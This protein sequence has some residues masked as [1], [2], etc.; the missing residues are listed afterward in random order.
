[1]SPWRFV[2]A[3]GLVSLLTDMVYEGA[4]SIIGPYLATL[5]ATAVV[6]GAVAGIGDFLGYGLRV[7]SGY[8]VQRSRR[9]WAWTIAGYALTVLSVPLIG[10]T[11]AIA[12]ALVLY[13][14]ERLGKAVRS[15][16]K[17]TLLSHASTRTGPG[18]AFG[19]HQAMDQF[20][21]MAGP[22]LLAAVLAG[23]E[24]DYQLAFGVL[25]VPGMLVI[26]LLFWLRLRVPAPLAYERQPNLPDVSGPGQSATNGTD[27]AV[28]GRVRLPRRL[29]QY[30]ATIGLLSV[31]V[32]PFPLMALHAQGS[33]ILSAAQVPV[34]FA[35]AMA[36]DGVTG[37]VAGRAYDRVGPRVLLLVP[38]AAATAAIS[39]AAWP[40]LVWVGVAVWGVVNGILDS[41]VKAVITQLV[42]AEERAAAFGWLA[43][44]RG[45]GLLVAGVALG[46]A[47][48]RSPLAAAA[49]ILVVNVVGLLVL[50]RVL[51]TV[52]DARRVRF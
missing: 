52:T 50:S 14:S 38:V 39:F 15:P 19:V 12:P 32:A 42:D 29:W 45:V 26:G 9:Y 23:S 43:L 25:A 22:L 33:G 10:F 20:G 27:A 47:Y 21:A 18:S 40:A 2:L 46:V 17:D 49:L 24:G 37:P 41:V 51:R 44:A 16:A 28:I 5:G 11:N 6:V 13:G 30:I 3:F 35:V 7:V 4:R 48:Q 31:G 8:L 36:I 1:L 34:L